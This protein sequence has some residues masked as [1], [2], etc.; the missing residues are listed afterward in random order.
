MRIAVL[1]LQMCFL[2]LSGKHYYAV[3]K[4]GLGKTH[5]YLEKNHRY[6]YVKEAACATFDD[7][8]FDF[9]EEHSFSDDAQDSIASNFDVA[10]AWNFLLSTPSYDRDF[11]KGYKN[12]EPY[13]GFSCPKYIVQRVI[14]I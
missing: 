1:L 2:L 12:P 4:D 11:R 14:R 7:S 5:S 9:E 10:T 3:S 6:K 13:C 8:D